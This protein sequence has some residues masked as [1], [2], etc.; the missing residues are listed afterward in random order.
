M[1]VPVPGSRNARHM[2]W[3]LIW[4]IMRGIRAG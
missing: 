3:P 1:N 4:T 2:T